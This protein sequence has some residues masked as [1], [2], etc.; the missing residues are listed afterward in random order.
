MAAI[1]HLVGYA[2]GAVDM[3]KVFGT[4]LGQTQFKQLCVISAASLLGCVGVTCWAV[5]E[6]VLERPSDVDKRASAAQ[7]LS[8]LFRRTVNLPPR[9][10]SICWVQFWSWIGWFPFLFYGTTWVGETYFRYE[11][12][13]DVTQSAD[14]RLGEI[15]RLGSMALVLYSTITFISSVVLPFFVLSPDQTKSATAS[16]AVVRLFG[17]KVTMRRPDLQTAWQ[18]AHVLFACFWCLSPFV[19]SLRFATTLIAISGIPWSVCNWAPFAFMGVEINRQSSAPQSP[20]ARSTSGVRI[21]L[22][23]SAPFRGGD[24]VISVRE[25]V[26]DDGDISNAQSESAS[27]GGELAGIYLGVLNVYTT[28]PQFV[29]TLIS[30]VVFSILDPQARDPEHS[31]GEL[32]NVKQEGPNPISVCLFIGAISACFAVEAARRLKKVRSG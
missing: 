31:H 18:A 4:T 14:D 16:L 29:G 8:Q 15:G 25:K 1:G 24:S 11:A 10:K 13:P 9:I 27:S 2:I 22:E 21:S 19:R 26:K 3:V 6:R 17:T 30:W 5:T 23:Q 7:I 28:I 12:S 20:H 32:G